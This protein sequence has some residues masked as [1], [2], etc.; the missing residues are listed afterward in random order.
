M[1]RS[2]MAFEF[3]AAPQ[4]HPT[5]HFALARPTLDRRN[6]RAMGTA[7]RDGKDLSSASDKRDA[8]IVDVRFSAIS[9]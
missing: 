3:A 1:S 5:H 9:A 2:T 8:A 6:L 4:A 7:F